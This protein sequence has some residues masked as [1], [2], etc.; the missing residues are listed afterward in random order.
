MLVG[1]IL[2]R[3]QEEA[4]VGGERGAERGGK[5]AEHHPPPSPTPL[6]SGLGAP[7]TPLNIRPI[8]TKSR[9]P[10]DRRD[11]HGSS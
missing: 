8:P 2:L 7:V 1:D 3:D 10:E 11:A 4:A 6:A 5:E 9:L